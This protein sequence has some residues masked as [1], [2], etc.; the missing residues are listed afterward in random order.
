MDDENGQRILT[1]EEQSILTEEE[2]AVDNLKK[3][4]DHLI[5]HAKGKAG[6]GAKTY[7]NQ[8]EQVKN[9]LE[10]IKKDKSLKENPEALKNFLRIRDDVI[11]KIQ[12]G[13]PELH[14]KIKEN[15]GIHPDIQ[16]RIEKDGFKVIMDIEG[17][18]EKYKPVKK[19]S[20]FFGRLFRPR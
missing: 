5:E 1:A 18:H 6:I 8:L 9:M 20:G 19:K 15:S 14:T 13:G 3:V 17:I 7:P 12:L 10:N 11:S 16:T 2:I 4:L